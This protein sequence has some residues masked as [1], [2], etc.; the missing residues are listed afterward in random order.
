MIGDDVQELS[1]AE[2]SSQKVLTL[3]EDGQP[4]INMEQLQVLRQI[5][6]T[7]M[8]R[9]EKIFGSDEEVPRKNTDSR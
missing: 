5:V 1:R 3:G 9:K 6:H 8:S 4:E 7:G 2:A